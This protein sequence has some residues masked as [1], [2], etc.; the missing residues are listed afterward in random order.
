MLLLSVTVLSLICTFAF[1]AVIKSCMGGTP[2]LHSNVES[3]KGPE[4]MGTGLFYG[5]PLLDVHT[6]RRSGKYKIIE[7]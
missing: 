6:G 7:G 1:A 4:Y 3:E 2:I 5:Y